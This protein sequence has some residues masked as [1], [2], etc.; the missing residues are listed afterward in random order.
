MLQRRERVTVRSC[1]PGQQRLRDF[2]DE[3]GDSKNLGSD[4][5]KESWLRGDYSG[6][7]AIQKAHK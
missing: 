5:R 1:N 4:G 6:L 7:A 3:E 2:S